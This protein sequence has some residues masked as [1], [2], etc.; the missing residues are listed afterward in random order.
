M[1]TIRQIEEIKSKI[2]SRSS[3]EELTAKRAAFFDKN[4]PDTFDKIVFSGFNKRQRGYIRR[5]FKVNEG[6]GE[7]LNLQVIKDGYFRLVSESY[8]ANTYPGI[9]Y[10][11][12]RRM[13]DFH[14]A[15]RPQQNFKVDFGGVIATR[16]ISNLYLGLSYYRFGRMLT[17]YYAGFQTGSFYKSALL[18]ARIDFPL[19]FYLEPY[20][21]YSSWDFL[22]GDDLLKNVATATNPT[23]LRRI[24][25]KYA[26]DVGLPL[27][28][29][30]KTVFNIEGFSTVDR[31]VNGNIFISTDTLDEHR[32]NGFKAGL[33]IT[34]NTLNRK[35]YASSGKAFYFSAFYFNTNEDYRPGN[36]SVKA[37][38]IKAHHQWF[39]V[40]ATSEQFFGSSWYR[41]GYYAEAVFSNQP[42]FQNYYGTII[43]A[44]SFFPIQDSRALILQNFRSF[45]YLAIGSKN[46]FELRNKLD[47]RLEGYLFKPFDYVVETVNQ[48]ASIRNSITQVFFAGTA[49]FVFHSAIGPVSLSMNYYDDP[50]NRFGVLLHIGFLLFNNHS[51]E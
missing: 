16:D 28:K 51:L 1:Q 42:F 46:V 24:N 34:S 49:G 12:T 8:F 23:V 31:Y 18:K 26:L 19:P 29:S 11:S 14:L 40:K 41:P 25:R 44:P 21:A 6:R 15:R 3:P 48:E 50:E 35:Q 22:Q 4:V 37:G 17:H 2:S 10:D 5:Y 7:Q 20:T 39:R 47:F 27:R 36:T 38:E 13:F 45:N 9:R 43:N 32:L 33:R 30:Y